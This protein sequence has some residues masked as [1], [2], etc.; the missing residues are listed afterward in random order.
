M[1]MGCVE[2]Q[3]GRPRFQHLITMYGQVILF[4][5]ASLFVVFLGF[6]ICNLGILT[7]L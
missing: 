3:A 1:V 5:G 6:L 7:R 4:L 2:S